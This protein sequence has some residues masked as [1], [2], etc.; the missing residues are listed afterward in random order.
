MSAGAQNPEPAGAGPE[1]VGPDSGSGSDW[2]G[3][4][5]ENA[6]PGP[7]SGSD[8]DSGTESVRFSDRQIRTVALLVN[9]AAGGGRG[10]KVADRAA[11]RLHFHGIEV[12]RLEGGSAEASLDLARR[13]VADGVDALVVCGGD[14]MVS[15]AVQAQ[16]FSDIP[17]GIIP[18]GTG[19]DLARDYDIPLDGPEAAADVVAAGRVEHVDLGQA[20]PDGGEPQVFASILCAGLDSKVNRRVNEM[21]M[22]GGPLRYVIASMIEFPVYRPRRFR[23]TFDAGLPSEET[24]ESEVLLSAF[25]ITRSYGGDMKIAPNADR[26][27]GLFD[28]CYIGRISKL[29]F[30][31]NF[32]KIYSGGHVGLDGVHTRRCRTVRLEA[33]GVEAFADGDVVAPLPVTVEVLPGAGRFLVPR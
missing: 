12:T 4:G 1:N 13:A 18:A 32:P 20:T 9:P 30:A 28:V 23:M 15:L 19:N 14:G 2:A 25:A 21:K 24:V 31:R 26:A 8:P 3:T 7:G 33:A 22:L 5:P 27:D 10:A 17:V 6:G 11:E 29:R 16:A